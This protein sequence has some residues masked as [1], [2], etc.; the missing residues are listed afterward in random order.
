[1]SSMFQTGSRFSRMTTGTRI[2]VWRGR[3]WAGLKVIC[4][5]PTAEATGG[6]V[7]RLWA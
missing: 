3:R 4:S 5:R 2:T 1:M 6:W 7:F